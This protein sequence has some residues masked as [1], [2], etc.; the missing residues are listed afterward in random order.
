MLYLGAAL[1]APVM[2]AALYHVLHGQAAAVRI[3]DG[4]VYVA[5]PFLVLWQVLP[6]TWNEQSLLPPLIIGSGVLIPN[7]LERAS[8]ALASQTD[9]FAIL[10]GLSGLVLHAVLE[11]V[12]LTPGSDILGVPFV[13]A[14]TLH[15]I[16]VGLVI[17]WLICPRHGELAAA[18]AVVSVPVATAL[19]YVA[20]IEFLGEWQGQGLE[21]YQAFVA[22]SLIH[23]VFHQG[24]HDHR[25]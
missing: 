16:P 7:I 6:Y 24:R 8:N 5:V 1:V 9:N 12:A 21:L 25:H 22:G 11:G 15:R 18:A 17:W 13:A 3:V 4:F 23:V 10:L 19:G 2:G 20:G 14:V